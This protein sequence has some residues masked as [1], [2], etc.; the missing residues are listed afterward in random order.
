M[1]REWELEDLIAC[2][3]LD[4]EEFALLANKSGATR[5]GFSLML[6]YFEQEARFPR[7]EDVPRAAVEFVAGQVKV[8]AELFAGYDF[9][10]RQAANHRTQIRDFHKFAKATLEDEDRLAVWLATDICPTETARDRLRAALLARC[11]EL[12]I[13]PPTP[14]RIER[15]LGEAEALFAKRFTTTTQ[16]RLPDGSASRLEELLKGD[17]DGEVVG[18]GRAFLQELKEDPGPLQLDT[19]FAEIGKL[20][21]VKVIGLPPD[22]FEGVSEKVVAAWRAR[23]MRMYPSDFIAA[24]PPVRLTLLAALCHVRRTELIDG[25]VELLIQMVHKISVRAE[26]KVEGEIKSEFRRVHGKNGILVKLATAALAL[27]DEIVRKALYPVVGKR[28]LEDIIAEAKANEKE[29]N[30]RVRTKLRGSYSH[31]Y[32]RGLPKLLKAVSF[33]SNNDTFAPVMDALALLD[34]Y[35]DSEADFYDAADTVPLEHVVPDDWSEAVAGADTGLVER[36]PYELCVLVALRKAIRRREIWVEG[37]NTW[38]NP[39]HDLPADFEDNRDVHYQALKKPREPAEFIADLQRRHTEALNRLD[40]ALGEGTTGGVKVTKKKGEPW[41]SVPPVMKQAEPENLKALKEEIA[42]RW[43]VIDLLDLIKNV[44]HAT[45]FTGDFTSVASRTVTD[46]DVL[47]RRLLLCTFGL[48]TNM[49][50]KRVADGTAAVPGLE[51]DTEAALRRVRRM[52]INRDNLRAAIRTV[53]NKTLQARDTDLWG[54]GTAC[55]SDSRKFGSWSANMLTEW[56]QRYAGAGIMVY[57]HVERKNVCIYSQ[58]RSTTDSEVSSMIEGL[59][60]HLT[61][62][63]ID[64]Q[65][66]DTH[67][68]SVVGFAFSHLLDFKLLPRLKNI[69]SARLYRPGLEDDEA[70][71]RLEGVL[72]GKAI[73]WQL[74][75]NQYDQMVKYATALRLGTAEAHQMLRRFTR[76]GP[77][78]PTYR[79][80]EELGRVIRTAFICDYLADEELRREIHEGLNVVENWNSANKD[81]FYG[82]AGDLTGDDKEH[83]EVSALSLHLVQAAIVYLNTRMIQAVLS[84][85]TWQKKLT[86]ND[87]R[88][89]SGLFWTHI[90]LY[91]RFELNMNSRLDLPPLPESQD[92]KHAS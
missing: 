37:G 68:A 51:A 42:S 7:R 61:S 14:G 12:Q 38:R 22:L 65:Y 90:N 79:A 40:K 81:I 49:G 16:G 17:D 64:R 34:R 25:L 70:W 43:G 33:K 73:D 71:P 9:A 87:R 53:V 18:G 1:R 47:R 19:L 56:H 30:T 46:A 24:A 62:A 77:K 59:L 26:K 31:H 74:I 44:D 32:R 69:G 89:L 21:R 52:F 4:E 55:A 78:H 45:G 8:S 29:F 83:V 84:E 60:R 23:A 92:L 6:K 10:S 80:I 82:K 11:R 88:A 75:S 28:T 67:G 35:A 5:L 58:V 66:T 27:P 86:D 20:E 50:I 54:P 72:S 41:I 15:V 2:W 76:G 85:P 36:I 3:T 63:E 48:G 13:E 91:G 57:W 39:D